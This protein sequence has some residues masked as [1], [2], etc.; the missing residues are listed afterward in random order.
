MLV[1][2]FLDVIDHGQKPW[3]TVP[4]SMLSIFVM[5]KQL[6]GHA[7]LFQFIDR[8]LH[9]GRI[10]GSAKLKKNGGRILVDMEMSV[11]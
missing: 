3:V 11:G 5:S 6:G 10:L 7:Q 2:P 9:F 4:A 1:E 8:W